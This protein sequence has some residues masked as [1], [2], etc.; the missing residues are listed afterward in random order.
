[1]VGEASPQLEVRRWMFEKVGLGSGLNRR[2]GSMLEVVKKH[3]A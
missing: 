2:L 3:E 1:M